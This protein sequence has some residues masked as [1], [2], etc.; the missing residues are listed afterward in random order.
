M[1]H[2]HKKKHHVWLIFK[3]TQQ[4]CGHVSNCTVLMQMM[5]VTNMELDWPTVSKVDFYTLLSVIV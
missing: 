2:V 4:P 1:F 3:D 5:M